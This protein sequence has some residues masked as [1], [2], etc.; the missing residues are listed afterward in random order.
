M[1]VIASTLKGGA[2]NYQTPPEGVSTTNYWQFTE[3]VPAIG[4][5]GISTAQKTG[6]FAVQ[7]GLA[8]ADARKVLVKAGKYLM[9]ATPTSESERMFAVTLST[10]YKCPCATNSTGGTRYDKILLC[11]PA[12]SL[13][14][15]AVTGDLTEAACIITE[16]HT[17]AGEAVTTANAIEL[18]EVTLANGF[19]S[20]AD[21]VIKDSRKRSISLIANPEWTPFNAT[22]T[23]TA[24]TTA[25]VPGDFTNRVSVGTKFRW[26]SNGVLR[27]NYI[28]AISY[29]SGTGLTTITITSGYVATAADSI[30]TTGEVIW[31]AEYSKASSPVGFP[32]NSA[33]FSPIGVNYIE[34]TSTIQAVGSDADVTGITFTCNCPAGR[35]RITYS[36]CMQDNSATN[37]I[38]VVTLYED[39]TAID[40]CLVHCGV[41][42]QRFNFSK[43]AV[44]TVT[45]GAH[46]Y[47]IK[48]G[49]TVTGYI[50]GTTSG[51]AISILAELV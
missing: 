6:D 34:N 20:I 15:P 21:T 2:S 30:F 17:A 12:A 14:A 18:A 33:T 41:A 50:V 35:L 29:A 19:A 31:G 36:F 48:V 47:K 49:G 8:G 40:Q 28:T 51:N 38:Y 16:R 25:T 9:K 11:L 23:R 22:F 10:D 27:H 46:T 3:G 7:G 45:A 32:Q 42:G 24:D 5:F 44:R 43:V 26:Y 39:S 37:G 1:T 4:S 13:A